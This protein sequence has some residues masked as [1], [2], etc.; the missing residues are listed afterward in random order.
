MLRYRNHIL[1]ALTLGLVLAVGLVSAVSTDAAPPP[2]PPEYDTTEGPVFLVISFDPAF[3]FDH[4]RESETIM[5]NIGSIV[6]G[7]DILDTR[8]VVDAALEGVVLPDGRKDPRFADLEQNAATVFGSFYALDEQGFHSV[9]PE[10]GVVAVEIQEAI[11]EASNSGALDLLIAK[12]EY[13][14][15]EEIAE[16]ITDFMP[17]GA[18]YGV[19]DIYDHVFGSGIQL[20]QTTTDGAIEGEGELFPYEPNSLSIFTFQFGVKANGDFQQEISQKLPIKIQ[21]PINIDEKNGVLPVTIQSAHGFDASEIDI[22]SLTL[23]G[24]AVD[25]S[26][27]AL[28]GDNALV[29]KFSVPA[30]VAAGVLTSSTTELTIRGTF[31]V[32]EDDGTYTVH[33]WFGVDAVTTQ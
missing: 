32:L 25:V 20:S 11:F 29:A 7:S 22:E 26:Q 16:T 6:G 24:I 33:N 23:D 2:P 9:V 12:K 14:T 17:P 10:P 28:N 30:L 15:T 27:T 21:S 19:D 4:P 18:P 5:V 31:S 13:P 3:R 1:A 8:F